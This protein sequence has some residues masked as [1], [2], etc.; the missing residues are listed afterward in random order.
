MAHLKETQ[1]KV[2]L[3]SQHKHKRSTGIGRYVQELYENLQ[4]LV[5]IR[6]AEPKFLPFTDRFNIL[7]NFPRGI[8]EHEP[9]SIVHFTQIM[10]CAQ[11]LWNPVHPAIATVHDLGVLVCKEDEILWRKFDRKIL[12]LQLRGLVKVDQFIVHSL[13]TKNGL[14]NILGI[15]PE[16]ITILPTWIN[17]SHFKPIDLDR[18]QFL[19]KY[20]L[21]ISPDTTILLYI[22][23]E[24]PRKNLEFL[25]HA[26]FLLRE[27]GRKV[28]LIKVG[29]PGGNQWRNKVKNDIAK[30]KLQNRVHILDFIPEDDLPLI[31]NAA[32]I[33][34]TPTLLE[35]TFAWVALSAMA[36]GKPSIVTSSALIPENALP[37][38][39]VVENLDLIGYVQGILDLIDNPIISAEKGKLGR[40]IINRYYN[41]QETVNRLIAIYKK[42]V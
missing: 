32:D 41:G 6:L 7:T 1:L 38:T 40:E 12:D 11:M 20:G 21:N 3:V 22:G 26:V 29:Q 16:V 2:E 8:Q 35:S 30:Y 36:C 14:I 39:T 4:G 13:F 28:E 10:G 34:A 5:F 19:S 31:I 15:K 24:L 23:T 9:G 27:S 42:I 17:T 25:L 37:A 33:C 18:S